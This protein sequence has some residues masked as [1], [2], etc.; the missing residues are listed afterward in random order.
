MEGRPA[1]P[2][3]G[4]F[5]YAVMKAPYPESVIQLPGHGKPSECPE[6]E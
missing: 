4:S 6:K 3:G 2:A 5:L 1:L